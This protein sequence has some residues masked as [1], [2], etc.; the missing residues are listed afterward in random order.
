LT[1][2]GKPGNEDEKTF[3]KR[4]G[5]NDVPPKQAGLG[6]GLDALLKDSAKLAGTDV[7]AAEKDSA[8]GVASRRTVYQT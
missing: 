5:G 7:A 6:K 4:D 1:P 2:A 3:W 8:G